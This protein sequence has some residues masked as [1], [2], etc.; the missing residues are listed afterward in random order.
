MPHLD[1]SFLSA[2]QADRAR[3]TIA[4]H[5]GGDLDRAETAAQLMLISKR[6]ILLNIPLEIL[7]RH[8][9]AFRDTLVSTIA[10][11]KAKTNGG[12]L[13]RYCW[14]A[15]VDCARARVTWLHLGNIQTRGCA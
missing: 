14:Q 5:D 1:P 9:R 8:D 11:D 12:D 4:R 10:A 2:G 6:L 13:H 15:A 3:S 7:A